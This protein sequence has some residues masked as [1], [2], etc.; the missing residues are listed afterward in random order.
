MLVHNV[1][2][3]MQEKGYAARVV[4]INHI[5]GIGKELQVLDDQKLLNADMHKLL[6]K[7]YTCNFKDVPFDVKS[8]IVTVSPCFIAKLYFNWMGKRI[9]L[10]IPPTYLE[11][12]KEPAK[13]EKCLQ[14]ILAAENYLVEIACDLPGKIIAAKCGLSR[15]GRNNIGYIP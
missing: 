6:K 13:I 7:Y 1:I 14:E 4:P 5:L 10:M 11:Y 9:P 15:Y 2:D 12:R 3:K 8:V